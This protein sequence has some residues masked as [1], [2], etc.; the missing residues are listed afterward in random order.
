MGM[1]V[2]DAV[3][4]NVDPDTLFA[5][6]GNAE[7]LPQ[8]MPRVLDA[9]RMG[10]EVVRVTTSRGGPKN[11]PFTS[12]AWMRIEPDRHLEWGADGPSGYRGEA[13]IVPTDT[14]SLLMVTLHVGDADYVRLNRELNAMLQRIKQR[15]EGRPRT[16]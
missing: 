14:G 5:Y 2:S 7:K 10:N 6:I 1:D 4:V 12:E 13:S 8:Y 15:V 16:S 11:G 9:R 3:N